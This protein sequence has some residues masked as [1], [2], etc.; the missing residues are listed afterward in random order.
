VGVLTRFH[1]HGVGPCVNE[2][3]AFGNARQAAAV[4]AIHADGHAGGHGFHVIEAADAPAGTA[5]AA[6]SHR[7][8]VA[9]HN[10]FLAESGFGVSTYLGVNGYMVR[11][12][13]A[14]LE[15]SQ[16]PTIFIECGNMR[17]PA[18]AARMETAA[19]RQ[20]TAQAIADGVLGYLYS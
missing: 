14:G 20:R 12:D 9:V 19:G 13:L 3:A 1:D 8:A 6:S 5:T 17:D 7:L 18:D 2:R 15:L 16:R 4:V 11:T 10:R